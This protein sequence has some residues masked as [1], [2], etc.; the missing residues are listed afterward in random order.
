MGTMTS[1]DM[2]ALQVFKRNTVRKIY[3]P[4]KEEARE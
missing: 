4:I 2:N 3:G 1:E